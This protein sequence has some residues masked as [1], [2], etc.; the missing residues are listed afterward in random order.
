MARY[1]TAFL[2]L[3]LS[4]SLPAQDKANLLANPGF[5]KL[6]SDGTFEAWNGWKKKPE[7]EHK[8]S[9]DAR[10]GKHCAYLTTRGKGYH[11][12]YV[13]TVRLK[14]G[15]RYKYS[16]WIK[17]K[18]H[19]EGGKVRC[20]FQETSRTVDGKKKRRFFNTVAR[21]VKEDCDWTYM[22]NIFDTLPDEDSNYSIH[23][24]L[25]YDDVEVWVDDAQLIDC[26]P[27]L[28]IDNGKMTLHFGDG[29]NIVSTTVDKKS[30]G[31]LQ[32][33]LAQ[34]EKKGV[35]YKKTGVGFPGPARV[36]TF[37]VKERSASK[38]VVDVTCQ[39]TESR[40]TERKF[41]AVYRITV[42]AGQPWFESRLISIKNTDR[43]PYVVRG[44]YQQLQPA[45]SKKAK[46]RCFEAC[47]VWCQA[48]KAMGVAIRNPGDF[49]LAL[50]MDNGLARGDV[51]RELRVTLP[52]G[53]TWQGQE[54][55]VF[56]FLMDATSDRAAIEMRQ[57]IL[58]RPAPAGTLTYYE[59]DAEKETTKKE[60][61]KQ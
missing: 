33:R 60:Q 34:F 3:A 10:S 53:Q 6:K 48:P 44:Y 57:K 52:P 8:V 12:G 28:T 14:A 20:C 17:I 40:E 61:T 31:G 30:V 45:D 1:L 21:D 50:R 49:A 4:A 11:G 25:A 27:V 29:I 59:A 23:V 39:W 19:G 24:V 42:A 37:D 22:E 13:Q 35:G 56:V 54:P 2:I 43:V 9:D 5:E 15:C 47:A 7:I 18:T 55:G 38:C 36:K 58:S 16:A 51:T 26:G 32:C 41:E 46:P